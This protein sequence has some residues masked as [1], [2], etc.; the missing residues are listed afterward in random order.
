MADEVIRV[1]AFDTIQLDDGDWDGPNRDE[2]VMT[3]KAKTG[4]ASITVR[5]NGAVVFDVD[6][7]Q[8]KQIRIVGNTVHLPEG[9]TPD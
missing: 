5:K 7:T 9:G 2:D 1:A 3:Y 8:G 6:Y 4:A